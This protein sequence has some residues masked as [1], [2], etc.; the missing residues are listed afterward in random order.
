MTV[1]RE[2]GNISG[3]PVTKYQNNVP[4]APF[5]SLPCSCGLSNDKENLSSY[6]KQTNR[7]PLGRII[8]KE[9]VD[10][11]LHFRDLT[12]KILHSSGIEWSFD[13]PD[14]PVLICHSDEPERWVKAEIPLLNLAALCG[15]FM[16]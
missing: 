7:Q 16:S 11:E 10:E 14:N 1:L 8:K 15:G 5:L 6:F 12:N 2:N 9:G 3:K 13:D 4:I